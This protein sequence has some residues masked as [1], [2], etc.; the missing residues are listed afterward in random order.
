MS[1]QFSG[2]LYLSSK[3]FSFSEDSFF[4]QRF[5]AMSASCCKI[6]SPVAS[7]SSKP[8]AMSWMILASGEGVSRVWP[9]ADD[10]LV[11]IAH[12]EHEG[13]SCR[14][15]GY[16]PAAIGMFRFRLLLISVRWRI[17]RSLPASWPPIFTKLC[18]K[19][20]YQAHCLINIVQRI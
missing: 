11:M 13:L 15:M 7:S 8:L 3:R 2:R 9:V 19:A 20:C 18:Y 12:S 14:L 6:F 10:C 5:L 4:P 16:I 17:G 1:A